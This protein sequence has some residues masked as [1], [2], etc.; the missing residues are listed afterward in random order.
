MTVKRSP[1]LS[2]LHTRLFGTIGF[3]ACA[4]ASFAF[5]SPA[6]ANLFDA[7]EIENPDNFA[8]IAAPV[9]QTNRH[10]LLIV[11]QLSDARACWNEVPGAPTEI[12]PLLLSFNFTGICGRMGDSNAYSVRVAG[13]DLGLQY[14]LRIRERSGDSVLVAAP[15]RASSELP[16]LDIGRA[17]GRAD[18]FVKLYLDPAWRLARRSY[19]GRTLGHVYLTS[20]Y[21]LETLSALPGDPGV[22][23][24]STDPIDTDAPLDVPNWGDPLVL[25]EPSGANEPRV[26]DE[27]VIPE[28]PVARDLPIVSDDTSEPEN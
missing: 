3:V 26:S 21:S 20:D 9:G 18:G 28:A 11:E 19:Q 16:E 23:A 14:A 6:A 7:E 25:D 2:G 4:T 22:P 13:E 5:A 24:I 27:P 17:Y 1:L 8:L 10:Q 12:E 15:V